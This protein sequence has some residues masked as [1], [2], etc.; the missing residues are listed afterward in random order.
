MTQMN[1]KTLY[2]DAVAEKHYTQDW[3]I[4][5][6][7]NTFEVLSSFIGFGNLFC[8]MFFFLP[9]KTTNNLISQWNMKQTVESDTANATYLIHL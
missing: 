9:S 7:D 5:R 3:F 4:E 1:K 8:V 6:S 2:I